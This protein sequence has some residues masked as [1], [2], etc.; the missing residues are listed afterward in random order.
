[1]RLLAPMLRGGAC[2]GAA[3]ALVAACGGSEVIA[4]DDGDGTFHEGSP[5]EPNATP[6]CG[7][8]DLDCD[9]YT[10]TCVHAKPCANDAQCE[11]HLKCRTRLSTCA[12]ACFAGFDYCAPG[13][14]CDTTTAKCVDDASAGR[15]CLPNCT[16]GHECCVGSCSGPAASMP[17][18]CCACLPGE[19]NSTTCS[20]G[21]CGA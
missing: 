5:C 4:H 19:V 18:D 12:V 14:H 13:T 10:R 21:R 17:S 9:A 1:M 16:V 6:N 8:T 15:S 7:L 11:N 20:G 2:A 3:L